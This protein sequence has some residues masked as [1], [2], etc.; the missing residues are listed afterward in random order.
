M[1]KGSKDWQHAAPNKTYEQLLREGNA[2]C[3]YAPV[4]PVAAQYSYI[5]LYN[6][7]TSGVGVLVHRFTGHTTANGVVY[8]QS[9]GNPAAN[10]VGTVKN[11][12]ID[13]PGS[14]IEMRYGHTASFNSY[15]FEALAVSDNEPHTTKPLFIWVPP[16]KDIL[17]KLSTLNAAL[18]G[19]WSWFEFID[20]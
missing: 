6:P 3:G 1:P 12:L 13:G 20:Y 14:V 10:L 15:R 2:Y 8:F 11:R 19:I 16:G 4:S 7:A 18:V 17:A 5:Q 9:R